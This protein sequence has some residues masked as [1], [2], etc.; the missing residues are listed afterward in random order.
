ML[1]FRAACVQVAAIFLEAASVRGNRTGDILRVEKG[2]KLP[3]K[4]P[5]RAGKQKVWLRFLADPLRK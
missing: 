1:D 2:R 5:F 3:P 4:V